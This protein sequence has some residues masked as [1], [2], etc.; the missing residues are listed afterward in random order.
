MCASVVFRLTINWMVHA[1]CEPLP[2]FRGGNVCLFEYAFLLNLC[3]HSSIANVQWSVA[4][5]IYTCLDM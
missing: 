1:V 3:D 4:M 5:E 2:L